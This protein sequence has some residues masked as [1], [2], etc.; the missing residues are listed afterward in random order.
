[1]NEKNSSSANINLAGLTSRLLKEVLSLSSE[2]KIALL[3]D[4][5]ERVGAYKRKSGRISYPAE[6]D[7]AMKGKPVRGFISN[8]SESGMFVTSFEK[9]DEGSEIT[10][11]FPPPARTVP[12]KMKARVV[13][14]EKEGFAV[15]FVKRLNETLQK[16]DIKMISDLFIK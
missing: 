8:I 15:E 7:F 1:M 4:L 5:E 6:I 14:V 12:V 9:P 11:V 2:E 16:Y 10:M 3:R 13:R